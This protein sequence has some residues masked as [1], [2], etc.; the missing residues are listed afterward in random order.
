MQMQYY[1]RNGALPFTDTVQA[2]KAEMSKEGTIAVF[3]YWR[4]VTAGVQ[5]A[6]VVSCCWWCCCVL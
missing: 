1:T 6:V 5:H 2:L 3:Y 4:L